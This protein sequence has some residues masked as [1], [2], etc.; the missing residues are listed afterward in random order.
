MAS[1]IIPVVTIEIPYPIAH[2]DAHRKVE[3]GD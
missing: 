2:H 1:T 3:K